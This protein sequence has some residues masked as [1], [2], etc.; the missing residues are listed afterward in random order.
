MRWGHG[1]SLVAR[2]SERNVDFAGFQPLVNA[3]RHLGLS[4]VGSKRLTFEHLLPE[5]VLRRL[6]K[7]PWRHATCVTGLL[8]A[9]PLKIPC[10]FVVEYR[11]RAVCSADIF[12]SFLMA[13]EVRCEPRSVM[14]CDVA[15]PRRVKRR[16]VHGAW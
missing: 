7:R 3:R 16:K 9:G 14:F 6:F 4:Q 2:L 10:G 8:Y 13:S 15:T 11:A 5:Q 12:V 1:C